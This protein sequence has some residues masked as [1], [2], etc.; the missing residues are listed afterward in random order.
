S[1]GDPGAKALSLSFSSASTASSFPC[2]RTVIGESGEI[3]DFALALRQCLLTEEEILWCWLLAQADFLVKL[4]GRKLWSDQDV[5][6]A[7]ALLKSADASLAD[8]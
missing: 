3:D 4:A 2:G 8:M 1:S 5:T 6:T 7:A